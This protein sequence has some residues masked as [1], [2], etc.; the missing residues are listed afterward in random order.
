MKKLIVFCSILF[1]FCAGVF[2]QP[3]EPLPPVVTDWL[4]SFLS[5]HAWI[6]YVV[7]AWGFLSEVLGSIPY[8]KA[9]A[10]YQLIFGW[11]GWIIGLFKKKV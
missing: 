11:I 4:T 7:V 3:T 2:G 5:A 6:A 9:N 10:T 1:V 8:V